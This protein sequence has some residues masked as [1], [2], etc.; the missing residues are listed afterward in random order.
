MVPDRLQN[1][2]AA[3]LVLVPLTLWGAPPE[4]DPESH[5]PKGCFVY[6]SLDVGGLRKGLQETPLG[7]IIT[8]PGF[9]K[10]LGQLP[11]LLTEEIRQETREFTETMGKDLIE[12]SQLLTGE[13]AFGITGID[14][15]QGP[16]M[17]FS[18]D[19]G[20]KKK[21][22]LDLVERLGKLIFQTTGGG[23]PQTRKLKGRVITT[24]S[25]GFGPSAHYTILEGHLLFVVGQDIEPVID[26]FDGKDEGKSDALRLDP[27]YARG[28]RQTTGVT[29]AF[30]LFLNWETLRN[31][32]AGFMGAMPA[33]ESRVEQMQRAFVATGLDKLASLSCRVG[34]RHGDFDT[35]LYLDSPGGTSGIS[36]LVSESFSP[37]EDLRTAFSRIPA[38]ATELSAFS[39][40]TGRLLRG[41]LE[42]LR[43]GFPDLVPAL[44]AFER[45]LENATGLSISRDLGT[46]PKLNLYSFNKLPPSGGLLPDCVYLVRLSEVEPYLVVLDKISRRV[47]AEIVSVKVGDRDC[48][49]VMADRILSRLGLPPGDVGGSSK[50][51][52]DWS[53]IATALEP[54]LS[55]AFAPI[56][57]EWMV[58]ATAPQAI[59]RYFSSYQKGPFVTEEE[60]VS[61]LLRQEMGDEAAFVVLRGGRYFVSVYNT[62][63]SLAM[64]VAPSLESSLKPWGVN[65]AALPSGENFSTHFRDGFLLLRASDDG[66]LLH[67]RGVISNTIGSPALLTAFAGPLGQAVSQGIGLEPPSKGSGGSPAS[68]GERRLEEIGAILGAHAGTSRPYPYDPKGSLAA[69]QSLMD[70]GQVPDPSLLVHPKG[71]ERPAVRVGDESAFVLTADNVSY[72]LVPWKQGPRDSPS[73]L[74]VYE[75]KPY[76]SGG[77]HVLFV[78][79]DMKFLME[80]EFQKLLAEQ[81]RKYGRKEN[82]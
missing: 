61:N 39:I 29:P 68:A 10:A 7:R 77:R 50:G 59:E 45:N 15:M 63:V 44:D 41:F 72:E 22:L 53:Q 4:F 66:L 32:I 23:E 18:V 78:N 40:A 27:A 24:W 33:R 12:V 52:E 37:A 58:V 65:L 54:S 3:A 51:L 46:L 25:F 79:L 49:Y 42:K 16:K 48:A 13:V 14:M 82:G 26:R 21:E 28:K 70:S 17:L 11:E 9:R 64:L 8:H 34:F 60:G 76:E 2:V 75:K 20:A 6:A 35:R 80:D 43:E 62:A 55:L 30:T 67:G 47:G 73:R 1:L 31:T 38:G 5:F 74:L 36:G 56:D 81:K 71:E 19:L 57:S 69:F